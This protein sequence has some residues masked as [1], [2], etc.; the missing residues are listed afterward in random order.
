MSFFSLAVNFYSV[1]LAVLQLS[2]AVMSP[3]PPRAA[4][5]HVNPITKRSSVTY[6]CPKDAGGSEQRRLELFH[7]G[8]GRPELQVW[9]AGARPQQAAKREISKAVARFSLIFDVV[10]Q[11][12]PSDDLMI[13]GGYVGD[14][15]YVAQIRWNPAKAV[16]DSFYEAG[17]GGARR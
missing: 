6:S 7:D 13:V 5:H 12:G 17:P 10:P 3:P 11:C 15:R 2:P 16:L 4:E 14:R 9:R 8:N 1:G